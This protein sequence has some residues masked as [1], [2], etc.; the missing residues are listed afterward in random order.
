MWSMR[1]GEVYKKC[2]QV[3]ELQNTIDELQAENK[4][5]QLSDKLCP[6]G[7]TNT[8]GYWAKQQKQIEQLKAENKKLKA[9]LEEEKRECS[10]GWRRWKLLIVRP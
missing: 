3:Y 5:V 9:E 6:I 8:C 10:E 1:D 7:Q 2:P 4:Q